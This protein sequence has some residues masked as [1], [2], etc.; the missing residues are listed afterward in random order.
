MF[1]LKQVLTETLSN[2][3]RDVDQGVFIPLTEADIAAYLYHRLL[4][5]NLLSRDIHLDARILNVKDHRYGFVVG[6]VNL[7]L[8]SHQTAVSNPTLVIQIALFPRWGA[9]PA[10]L[11]ARYAAALKHDLTALGRLRKVYPACYCYELLADFNADKSLGYLQGWDRRT[12]ST[13]IARLRKAIKGGV[14]VAWLY[15]ETLNKTCLEWC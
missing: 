8:E 4:F 15:P 3:C 13:R 2:L 7:D 14:S 6:A 9:T 1:T 11:Y 5:A 10:Q 12:R